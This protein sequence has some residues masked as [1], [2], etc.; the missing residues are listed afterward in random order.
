MKV[1]T[2][3]QWQSSRKINVLSTVNVQM[4]S[5][6]ILQNVIHV[7]ICESSTVL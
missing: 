7:Y 1:Q 5:K 4:N 6:Q 2:V 3:F